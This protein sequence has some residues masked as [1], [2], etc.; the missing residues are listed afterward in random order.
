MT[1]PTESPPPLPAT[2]ATADDDPPSPLVVALLLGLS[3]ALL[4]SKSGEIKDAWNGPQRLTEV[5]VRGSS[6]GTYLERWVEVKADEA[7]G[8]DVE[9]TTLH[10]LKVGLLPLPAGQDGARLAVVRTGE[11]YLAA[12]LPSGV[13]PE[14]AIG[15]ALT[16]IVRPWPAGLSRPEAIAPWVLDT[17]ADE[18]SWFVGALVAGFAGICAWQLVKAARRKLAGR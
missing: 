18:P 10:V 1:A 4:V 12:F 14:K 8:T 6:P 13:A 16:G 11:A 3:I 15:K 2:A 7:A 17:T 5:E 9:Q